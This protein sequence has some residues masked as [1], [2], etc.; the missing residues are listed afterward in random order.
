VKIVNAKI[1][2][3][4]LKRSYDEVDLQKFDDRLKV[5]KYI[6]ILQER[7]IPLGFYFNFYLYGPYSTDLTRMAHQI[8][9]YNQAHNVK[10]KNQVFEDNFIQTIS[11]IKKHKDDI[12]WLECVA[13]IMFLKK[14]GYS[15][16]TIYDKITN[17][18]T[19]FDNVYI[20]KVWNELIE[21]RW[22]D[23]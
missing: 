17:K 2:A 20:A 4:L 18:I 11:V 5:Q 19:N 3:G 16:R 8:K 6:Y 10:F 12:K 14:N 13:S 22:V 1:L 7:G 21:I 23:E 9:D 15:K